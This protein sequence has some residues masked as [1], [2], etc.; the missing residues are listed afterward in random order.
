MTFT[1]ESVA[2]NLREKKFSPAQMNRNCFDL[3]LARSYWNCS[4]MENLRCLNSA[5]NE[6]I[7][8]KQFGAARNANVER[9]L[10]LHVGVIGKTSTLPK[11]GGIILNSMIQTREKWDPLV[12]SRA[13]F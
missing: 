12:L 9:R 3:I 7:S 13:D 2:N 1:C 10:R 8:L 4:T 11:H 6:L 5:V